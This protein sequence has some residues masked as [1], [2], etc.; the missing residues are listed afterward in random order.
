M[1]PILK[2]N[3]FRD[4]LNL[5]TLLKFFSETD[6]AKRFILSILLKIGV[7]FKT[8]LSKSKDV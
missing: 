1:K 8:S 6:V 5:C 3:I 7:E 2:N 4:L